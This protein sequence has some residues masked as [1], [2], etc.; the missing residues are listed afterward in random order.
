M[1]DPLTP[2]A[3]F[4]A[5]PAPISAADLL[6]TWADREVTVLLDLPPARLPAGFG[7]HLRRS[8][9][10]ALGAAASPAARAGLPCTW[11]PPCALDVFLREQLRHA[12]DGLPKPY[13]LF[14]RAEND[15]LA[16][17]LRVFGTAL[18]WFPAVAEALVAGL[19]S[20]LPWAR[21]MPG[22][23]VAPAILD[24]RLPAPQPPPP[25][26]EGPLVLRLLSPLDMSGENPAGPD[27]P[28]ARIVG[29]MLRRVDAVARWQ[30]LALPRDETARLS[31][32]ARRLVSP[33]HDLRTSRHHAPNRRAEARVSPVATGW[34]GV[35]GDTA[36]LSPILRVATRT[37]LGRHTN[38]G[39][40]VL[41]WERRP[42][43][44]G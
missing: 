31:A 9:L 7:A 43:R 2:F 16:V 39:L 10:A 35:E 4:L 38:E 17:T 12:G 14:H 34:I 13:V 18:D 20:I 22:T 8:F 23:T 25:L 11:D 37:H 40:G 44:Q 27:D 6:A 26:P 41:T 24:R 21:V 32:A 36:L 19:V 30:G 29:R 15:R 42:D 1:A 33:G 3:R 5:A 28:A